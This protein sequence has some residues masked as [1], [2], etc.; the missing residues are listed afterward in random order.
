MQ[1]LSQTSFINVSKE[2]DISIIL[3]GFVAFDGEINSSV[4]L[5]REN[6]V[7]KQ[8]LTSTI[9]EADIRIIPH[10]SQAIKEELNNIVILSNDT[11]VAVLVLYCMEKFVREGLQKLW[12]RYGNGDHTR[13]LPI[14]I[15][16]EKLGANF[17]SVLLDVHILIGCDM[18]S[19][20]GTKES[21]IKVKPDTFLHAFISTN[22]INFLRQSEEYLVKVAS[23]TTKC[24]TFD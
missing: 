3:S 11:D 9:E 12:I 23:L 15:M 18:R 5:Q 14:H 20:V 7:I 24:T 19:K 13:Y 4:K 16:Y 2:N 6:S 10:V 8:D 17:C 22:E 1:R 21:T